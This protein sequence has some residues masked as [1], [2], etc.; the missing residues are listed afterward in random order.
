METYDRATKTIAVRVGEPVRL[1]LEAIQT[2]GYRWRPEP[3]PELDITEA[4]HPKTDIG[5]TTSQV[6]TVR[7]RKAGSYE[8]RFLYQRPWEPSPTDSTVFRIHSK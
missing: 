3:R 7:A 8:L 4:T 2:A 1:R 5:G 6:F